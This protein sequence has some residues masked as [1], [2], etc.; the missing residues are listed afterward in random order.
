MSSS[1]RPRKVE[2][3]QFYTTTNPFTHPAFTAWLAAI[4]VGARYLEPF[5]G[6]N[7]IVAMVKQVLPNSNW[8][9]FDLEPAAPEVIMRDTLASFPTGY[10]VVITN[11]PYLAR[12]SA[13]R[14]GMDAAVERMAN[15]EDLYLFSLELCLAHAP[16]V[17]AIIPESFIARGE[18]TERLTFVVSLNTKMFDDTEHPV[19]LAVFDPAP[20]ASFD[21]Y[22]GAKRI[23]TWDE[24]STR[25]RLDDSDH[26]MRFNDPRG[27][28]GLVAVDS[29]NGPSIQFCAAALVKASEIKHTSRHRT[30]IDVPA[31]R[32]LSSLERGLVIGIANERLTQWRESTGDVLLSPFMGLRKD[33]VYRRRLDYATAGKILAAALDEYLGSLKAAS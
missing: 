8:E 31:M 30:R 6:A 14:R 5:A 26:T 23:G 13:R 22:V 17:A 21:V 16:R 2:H 19:C 27:N 3:G 28:V 10:D 12:N 24:V 20:S 18:L 4:P 9:S 1:T 33:G 32:K 7:N 25:G 15:W 29:T 11:P